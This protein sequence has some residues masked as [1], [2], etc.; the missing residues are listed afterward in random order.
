MTA[1]DNLGLPALQG[2]D[3]ALLFEL[4]GLQD[5]SSPPSEL[6]MKS[7]AKSIKDDERSKASQSSATRSG[8]RKRGPG[9][10]EE[11]VGAVE[12]LGVSNEAGYTVEVADLKVKIKKPRL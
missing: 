3:K 8:K 10:N 7:L 9:G 12:S 5:A 11:E 4:L 6:L 1:S 2:A